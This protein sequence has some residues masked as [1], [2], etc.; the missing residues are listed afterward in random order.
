MAIAR[1]SGVEVRAK[2]FKTKGVSG[3]LL[4]H[5]DNFGIL[6]ATHIHNDGFQR[7]SVGHELGHFFLDG[8]IDHVLRRGTNSH[9]SMA[10]SRL[11]D[12]YEREADYF[13]AEL[14]MPSSLCQHLLSV[15]EPG[16]SAIEAMSAACQTSLSATAIQYARLVKEPVAVIGS[17]LGV[18]DY[19]FLSRALRTIPQLAALRKGSRVP[20]RS[21]THAFAISPPSRNEHRRLKND[22]DLSDWFRGISS[23][24]AIEEALYLRRYGKTLTIL[25]T[26]SLQMETNHDLNRNETVNV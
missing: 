23:I 17:T 5:G 19:C 16:L 15:L 18:V 7:F 20:R 12:F 4:R 26:R 13:S 8:H 10:G 22:C 11:A 9:T 21:S 6:Y 3:M 2:P 25:T 1:D 24:N 14:L